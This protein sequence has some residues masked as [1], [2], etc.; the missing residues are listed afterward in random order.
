MC[1]SLCSLFP[2][3][4][5]TKIIQTI[6]SVTARKIFIECPQV[7]KELWDGEFCSD[8][9]YVNTVGQYDSKKTISDY[10]KN[11]DKEKEYKQLLSQQLPMFDQHGLL[12]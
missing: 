1:I 12:G 2:K 8:G 7:K 11:Q 4:S 10:V 6:K 9:Y 5:A 3:N